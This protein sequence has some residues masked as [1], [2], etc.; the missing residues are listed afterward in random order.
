MYNPKA[1]SFS[2]NSD[3][4]AAYAARLNLDIWRTLRECSLDLPPAVT[5]AFFGLPLHLIEMLRDSDPLEL[6]LFQQSIMLKVSLTNEDSTA[7]SVI[8][9]LLASMAGQHPSLTPDKHT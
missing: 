7:H 2:P 3:K 5:A 4:L 9:N 8:R 6:P 1:E